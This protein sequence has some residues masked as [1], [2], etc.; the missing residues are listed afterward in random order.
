MSLNIAHVRSLFGLG[1]IADPAEAHSGY[2]DDGRVIAMVAH[3]AG[4]T[5]EAE[6]VEQRRDFWRTDRELQ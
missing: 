2:S 1:E 5:E 3:G 6:V 4:H